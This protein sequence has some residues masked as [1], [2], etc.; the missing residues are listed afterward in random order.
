MTLVYKPQKPKT[1][2]KEELEEFERL[3]AK[4]ERERENCVTCVHSRKPDKCWKADNPEVEKWLRG[5]GKYSD[6]KIMCPEWY[7]EY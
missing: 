4:M 6:P 3:K 1:M 7:D 5:E 2:T